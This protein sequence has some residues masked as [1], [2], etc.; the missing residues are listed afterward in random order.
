MLFNE[1]KTTGGNDVNS[2]NK[3]TSVDT[4]TILNRTALGP[5]QRWQC[6]IVGMIRV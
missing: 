6:S 2:N 5:R 4:G 1:L 3:I